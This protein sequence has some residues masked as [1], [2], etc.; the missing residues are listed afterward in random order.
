MTNPQPS[1]WVPEY[2]EKVYWRDHPYEHFIVSRIGETNNYNIK[3]YGKHDSSEFVSAV[4][5]LEPIQDPAEAVINAATRVIEAY[6]IKRHS[7][8]CYNDEGVCCCGLFDLNEAI[9]AYRK[10]KV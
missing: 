3:L 7:E 9:E 2:G 10:E 6:D 4:I 5:D 8:L 1:A